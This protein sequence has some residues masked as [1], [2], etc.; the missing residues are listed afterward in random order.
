M[1][2]KFV[3]LSALTLLSITS[4]ASAQNQN[5]EDAKQEVRLAA[6]QALRAVDRST[7]S[8]GEL[9]RARDQIRAAIETLNATTVNVGGYACLS[10]D[11]NS[12]APYVV[13]RERSDGKYDKLADLVFQE[14]DMCTYQLRVSIKAIGKKFLCASADRDGRSPYA[15]YTI[16]EM[17]LAT[18]KIGTYADMLTCMS[19]YKDGQ[20]RTDYIKSCKSRDNDGRSPFVVFRLN[21]DGSSAVIGNSTYNDFFACMQSLM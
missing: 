6:E 16:D 13:G 21:R 17:N 5:R 12:W 20:F 19:A 4:S 8:T 14:A 15:V 10:R 2:L 11:N 18:Q 9:L 3:A 7:V 1:N